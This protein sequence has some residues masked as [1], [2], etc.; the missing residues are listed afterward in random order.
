MV[1]IALRCNGRTSS[2]G[3]PK[4]NLGPRQVPCNMYAVHTPEAQEGRRQRARLAN[5]GGCLEATRTPKRWLQAGAAW[6]TC[7]H[8]RTSMSIH[9]QLYCCTRKRERQSDENNATKL[10]K[11]RP[12]RSARSPGGN[13]SLG[14]GGASNSHDSG[15]HLRVGLGVERL[16]VEMRLLRWSGRQLCRGGGGMRWGRVRWPKKI[17]KARDMTSM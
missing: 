1:K 12:T 7:K 13:E 9:L 17:E 11:L 3:R 2:N 5:A 8:M 16:E 14:A 10:G 6:S 4:P 15:L